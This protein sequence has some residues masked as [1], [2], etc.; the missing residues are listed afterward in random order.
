MKI[1]QD[2]AAATIRRL[3]GGIAI[4]FLFALAGLLLKPLAGISFQAARFW[5]S[6]ALP[7]I[8]LGAAYAYG[9]ARRGGSLA[10]V[11]GNALILGYSAALFRIAFTLA[12]ISFQA[13][14]YYT[15]PAATNS[16]ILSA[17]VNYLLYPLIPW[18]AGN[19]GYL[20]GSG[21]LGDSLRRCRAGL[22]LL[23][24]VA[25]A[26]FAAQ[27]LLGLDSAQGSSLI[28][29]TWVLLIAAMVYAAVIARQGGSFADLLGVCIALSC[30]NILVAL[31]ILLDDGAGIQTWYTIPPASGN[32]VSTLGH[33]VGHL[34]AVP[35][36][37][38]VLWVPASLVYLIAGGRRR[39]RMTLQAAEA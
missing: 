18:A 11:V 34:M 7:F 20:S 16:G 24:I 17:A 29:I 15:D 3:S 38:S 22:A 21:K 1:F 6:N 31:F 5:V 39:H 30:I 12:D 35:L 37:G 23:G 33:M 14:G 25:L 32:P 9:I 36:F 13:G 8:I 10:Q 2:S 26:R 19:L 28:S 27:P 4:L